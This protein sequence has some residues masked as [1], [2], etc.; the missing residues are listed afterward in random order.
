V[1]D[2]AF[3]EVDELDD[4]VREQGLV[5]LGPET[6]RMRDPAAFA[7]SVIADQTLSIFR[8]VEATTSDIDAGGRRD[9]QE[10]MRR[11][12]EV[13]G[14]AKARLEAMSLDLE[15][16]AHELDRPAAERAA[17]DRRGR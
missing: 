17:E 8:A 1:I 2:A 14:P 5:G 15:A 11:S 13:I 16:L 7:A 3:P 9:A 6:W 12:D 10:I 4:R